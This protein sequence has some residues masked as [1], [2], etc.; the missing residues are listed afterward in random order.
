MYKFKYNSYDDCCFSVGRYPNGNIAIEIWS[1]SEGPINR[2]TINAGIILP[3][4]YIAVKNYSENE[5][6]YS[7]NEGI[8]D[9]LKELGIIAEEPVMTIPSGF[10]WVPIYRLTDKGEEILKISEI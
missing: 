6:I 1:D 2:T 7:E 3:D 5:G 9:F 4:E 8:V 10:I